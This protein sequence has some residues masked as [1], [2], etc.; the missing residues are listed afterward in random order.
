VPPAATGAGEILLKVNV[1]DHPYFRRDGNDILIDV[2]LSI[3]EATLGGKVDV[4]TLDGSRLEVK[5]PAGTGSGSKLRLRGKGISGGDQF[6]VFKVMPPKEISDDAKDL[7][8]KFTEA[9]SYDPR[10]GVLWKA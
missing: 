1:A 9:V 7:M 5:I 3:G 8:Q 10:A 2:P 4:P 6:L